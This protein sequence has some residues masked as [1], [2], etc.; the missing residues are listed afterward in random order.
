MILKKRKQLKKK[1]QKKKDKT[2][3]D[4]LEF[5]N[6]YKKIG[7]IKDNLN[8]YNVWTKK[9]P[10]IKGGEKKIIAIGL[11]DKKSNKVKAQY[12]IQYFPDGVIEYSKILDPKN[13]KGNRL[14]FSIYPKGNR[15]YS[16]AYE[17]VEINENSE[18][19]TYGKYKNATTEGWMLGVYLPNVYNQ[20]INN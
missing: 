13:S 20:N 2:L 18:N 7:I 15:W 3:V 10:L 16:E 5:E 19:K 4:V 9:I 6:E 8:R 1:I 17:Y 14:L 11:N 12:Y